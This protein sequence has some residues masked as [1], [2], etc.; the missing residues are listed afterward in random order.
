MDVLRSTRRCGQVSRCRGVHS[1]YVGYVVEVD[2]LDEIAILHTVFNANILV[3]MVKV[4]AP[5]RNAD[6][7]KTFEVEAGVISTTQKAI[8]AEDEDG[9][10][11]RHDLDQVAAGAAG[12]RS[13]SGTMGCAGEVGAADLRDRAGEFA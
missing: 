1:G 4:F 6:R 13:C 7:S 12:R 2:I 9:V 3:L 5:L 10:E 11:G 8:A